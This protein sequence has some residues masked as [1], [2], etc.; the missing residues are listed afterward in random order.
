MVI[1]MIVSECLAGD[2]DHTTEIR[3]LIK[4]QCDITDAIV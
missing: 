3:D 1:E 4:Y 2:W